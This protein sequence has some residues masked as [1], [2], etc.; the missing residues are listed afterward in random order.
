MRGY[1]EPPRICPKSKGRLNVYLTEEELVWVDDTEL[2]SKGKEGDIEVP[3][4]WSG[5]GQGIHRDATLRTNASREWSRDANG[6][7]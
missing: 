4:E 2:L 7:F 3:Q 1:H 5:A 6:R